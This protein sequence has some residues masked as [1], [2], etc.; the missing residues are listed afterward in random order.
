V[1]LVLFQIVSLRYYN[2]EAQ[3]Q[4]IWLSNKE[5]IYLMMEI[6]ILRINLINRI[7]NSIIEDIY[8]LNI[9]F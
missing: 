4:I 6:G 7:L 8:W 5:D 1:K 9:D 2:V 3:G